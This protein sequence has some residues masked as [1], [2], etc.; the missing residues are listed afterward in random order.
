M[1]TV[2]TAL[3]L[4]VLAAVTILN[5]FHDAS[6]AVGAAVRTRALAPGVAIIVVAAWLFT[7]ARN[8]GLYAEGRRHREA[9]LASLNKDTDTQPEGADNATSATRTPRT[10]LMWVFAGTS[11]LATVMAA[12]GNW[13]T[14]IY[15]GD[16][17]WVNGCLSIAVLAVYLAHTRPFRR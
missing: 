2:L 16:S 11:A 9:H 10:Y 4:V 13:G 14:P 7:I 17:W 6:N 15:A 3:T 12:R 5:G 8:R 1:L